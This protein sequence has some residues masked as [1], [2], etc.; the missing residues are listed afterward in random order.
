M[1]ISG[2]F[3][4][5]D[6]FSNFSNLMKIIYENTKMNKKYSVQIHIK[7]E[8]YSLYV[9]EINSESKTNFTFF[10]FS[11]RGIYSSCRSINDTLQVYLTENFNSCLK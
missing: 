10:S 4:C 5:K 1:V 7:T 3:F 9:P 6:E 11:P 2:W 8:S